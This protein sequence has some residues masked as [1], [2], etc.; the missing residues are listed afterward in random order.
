[1]NKAA[2][3]LALLGALPLNACSEQVPEAPEMPQVA[4]ACLECHRND[5]GATIPG[6]PPLTGLGKDEI[7][8]KLSA[9]RNLGNPESRMTD[10]AHDLSDEEIEQLAQ[11]YG[12]D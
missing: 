3:L 5:G 7:R 9:Y 8:G 12:R 2:M 11:F 1:M 10:V 6:W 4:T